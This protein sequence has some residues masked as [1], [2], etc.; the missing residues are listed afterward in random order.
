MQIP[1]PGLLLRVSGGFLL[2]TLL[3][4]RLAPAAESAPPGK[5]FLAL[6]ATTERVASAYVDAYFRTDFDAMEKLSGPETSFDDATADTLFGGAPVSGRAAVFTH[7]RSTFAGITHISFRP[8]R[9][10]FSGEHAVFE[11]E[12]TWGYRPAPDAPESVTTGMP[13]VVII[14]VKDGVVMSHR[15]YG[16]Y[17]VMLE[18]ARATARIP[19]G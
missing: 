4:P 15:D 5:R 9:R 2:A 12:V 6:S 11:G 13:L 17:R 8:S 1:R 3:L 10:Y 16:D 18:Q 19:T 14:Q 7:L